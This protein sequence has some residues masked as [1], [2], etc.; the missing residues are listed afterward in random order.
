M[1]KLKELVFTA[2]RHKIKKINIV[3]EHRNNSLVQRFY[4]GIYT[5]EFKND[6][7]AALALYQTTPDDINYKHLKYKLE[8]RLIN[9][10]FFVDITNPKFNEI[11]RAYYSCYKNI[12][13]IA[14]LKG[15]GL[16]KSAISLSLRTI[17]KSIK[18]EFTDI[19]LSLART[20]KRHFSFYEK[21]K[22]KYEYYTKLAHE[23]YEL[24]GVEMM[25]EE[26]YEY[27]MFH[28]AGNKRRNNEN[29]T[30]EVAKFN[31]I[32]REKLKKFDSYN[33]RL[34][35]YI[36]QCLQYEIVEDHE[37][38]IEVSKQALSYFENLKVNVS[39]SNMSPYYMRI[40]ISNISIKN[41]AEA[42]RWNSIRL[43]KL[44][45]VIGSR[46]WYIANE[47][48]IILFFHQKKY[49][50]ALDV[51][52]T[53][54]QHKLFNSLQRDTKEIWQIYEA[55]IQYF[56]LVKKISLPEEKL[57]QLDKFRL[58]KFLNNVPIFSKD[59]E[60]INISILILQILFLL[61]NGQYDL[62]IDRMEAL[63]RYCYKYL[64]KDSSYRSK[65][66]IKM[67][68]ILIKNSFHKEATIR[69]AK[70]YF[71]KLKGE[72]TVITPSSSQVEVVPYEDLWQDVINSLDNK[73]VILR[74]KKKRKS[75][76]SK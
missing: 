22:K 43:A 3:G 28:T 59:K 29:I 64:K 54:K 45:G 42:T 35:Y 23:M 46:N 72:S 10:L 26:F 62:V 20:L 55:Y 66:F 38:V 5:D 69:K 15:R 27:I 58:N 60:G 68:I 56:V 8:K 49:Q 31:K 21:N 74:R 63:E 6:E 75:A 40:I 53:A 36:V 47:T 30:D 65:C 33:L 50:N 17:R 41:Y 51:L 16:R 39:P 57:K 7:D 71:D 9:T 32:L 24:S 2:S 37:N 1:D 12:G 14:I 34:M 13:A 76:S 25:A 52:L 67:L 44:N 19:T 70:A 18:F 11:Q 48:Q 4:Q 73:F 61:K